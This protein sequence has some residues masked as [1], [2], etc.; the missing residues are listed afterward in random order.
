MPGGAEGHPL[1]HLA[2]I[3]AHRVI[4]GDQLGDIHEITGGS[5]LPGTRIGHTAMIARR[6]AVF[7][8]GH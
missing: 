1:R 5:G 4:G 7:T 3:G 2:R 8:P 6:I